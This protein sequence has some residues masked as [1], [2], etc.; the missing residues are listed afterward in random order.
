MAKVKKW[1]PYFC[2]LLCFAFFVFCV[3]LLAICVDRIGVD[4]DPDDLQLAYFGVGVFSVVVLEVGG[5][6]I[7]PIFSM[8]K[9]RKKDAA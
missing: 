6:L 1:F 5:V 9:R 4:P 7:S 8:I 2:V 3:I